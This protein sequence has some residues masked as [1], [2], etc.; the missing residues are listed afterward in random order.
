MM[1]SSIGELLNR[2]EIY[3]REVD[4]IKGNIILKY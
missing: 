2:M 1:F 3:L 4:T